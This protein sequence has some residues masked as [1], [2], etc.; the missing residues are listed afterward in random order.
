MAAR[1]CR[2]IA[3]RFAPRASHVCPD[4]SAS[5]P[6]AGD[7]RADF[8]SPLPRSADIYMKFAWH[9]T[10]LYQTSP[11]APPEGAEVE[12]VKLRV[13]FDPTPRFTL[14]LAASDA[15]VPPFATARSVP[16]QFALLT[17]LRRA[18]N[19]SARF[20]LAVATFDRSERLF[21]LFR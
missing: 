8:N 3:E 21:A 10:Y 1:R 5:T 18:R 2:Q 4:L 20:V 14:A 11:L 12:A 17:V 15:P 16:D 9:Q 7:V 6:D 19:P 13:A